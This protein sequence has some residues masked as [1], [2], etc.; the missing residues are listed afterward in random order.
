MASKKQLKNNDLPDFGD[1]D[2]TF[3]DFNFGDE[4]GS[5]SRKPGSPIKRGVKEALRSH[6]TRPESYRAYVG[7]V[8]PRQYGEL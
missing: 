5:N 7:K 2:D 8:L 6:F 3:E 1:F 4:G